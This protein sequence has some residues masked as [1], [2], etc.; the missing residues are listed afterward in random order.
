MQM[1]IFMKETSSMGVGMVKAQSNLQMEG[2]LKV[3]GEMEHLLM[4]NSYFSLSSSLITIK[5]C[6]MSRKVPESGAE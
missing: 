6:C 4:L 3:F 1:E 5:A 2:Q